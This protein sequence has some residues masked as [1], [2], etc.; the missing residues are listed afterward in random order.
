MAETIGPRTGIKRIDLSEA[1]TDGLRVEIPRPATGVI[2]K[3]RDAA[4]Q[5]WWDR[6]AQAAEDAARGT[7]FQNTGWRSADGV[8]QPPE[9]LGEVYVFNEAADAGD[10]LV[11]AYFVGALLQQGTDRF[12][13]YIYAPPPTTVVRADG[14]TIPG[15]ST[16]TVAEDVRVDAFDAIQAVLLGGYT[17]AGSGNMTIILTVDD[18]SGSQIDSANDAASPPNGVTV[19]SSVEGLF[20]ATVRVANV[21][22]NDAENVNVLLIGIT[23]P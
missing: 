12:T 2:V 8:Y 22:T 1:H 20:K 14:I 13:D 10:E 7:T 19:D 3:S 16:A 17:R 9:P 18:E 23:E 21:G 15:S 4:C 6:D 5:V 11:L